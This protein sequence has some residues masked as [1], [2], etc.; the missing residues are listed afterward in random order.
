MSN[1]GTSVEGSTTTISPTEE[2]VTYNEN[3][4]VGSIEEGRVR[5]DWNAEYLRDHPEAST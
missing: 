3:D 1:L 5:R 2:Q 4:G